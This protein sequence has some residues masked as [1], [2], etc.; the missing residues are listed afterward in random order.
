[1][2]PFAICSHSSPSRPFHLSTKIPIH[3]DMNVPQH[4]RKNS[5]HRRTNKKFKI[6]VEWGEPLSNSLRRQRFTAFIN[7]V[8]DVQHWDLSLPNRSGSF[9]AQCLTSSLAIHT[10]NIEF[11]ESLESNNTLPFSSVRI[12]PLVGNPPTGKSS[13][14]SSPTI[15]PVFFPSDTE[16]AINVTLHDGSSII[17]PFGKFSLAINDSLS[18][19]RQMHTIHTL[20]HSWLKAKLS[21][22]WHEYSELSHSY[23]RDRMLSKVTKKNLLCSLHSKLLPFVLQEYRMR[24]PAQPFISSQNMPSI[25]KSIHLSHIT[26]IQNQDSINDDIMIHFSKVYECDPFLDDDMLAVMKS[27]LH[28]RHCTYQDAIRQIMDSDGCS[29]KY[30]PYSHNAEALFPPINS[31]QDLKR[32]QSL[33]AVCKFM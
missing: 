28:A 4:L 14:P 13:C 23:Q 27:T 29:S 20:H 11:V 12:S 24:L 3:C 30:S 1:M 8:P 5:P 26:L 31:L 22:T 16:K 17:Y 7:A 15:S 10:Q 18:P 19:A 32:W 33:D 25:M 2:P 21:V 9:S 6:A